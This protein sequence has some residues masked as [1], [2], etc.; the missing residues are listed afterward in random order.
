MTP[1]EPAIPDESRTDD[2]SASG[3]SRLARRVYADAGPMTRLMGAHRTRICPLEVVAASVPPGASVLDIGCGSGLML[4]ALAHAGRIDRGHGFDASEGAIKAAKG[5][6]ERMDGD[7]GRRVEFEHRRVEQG[8]P[9][10]ARD[11]VMMI[12][13]M[14]HVAAGARRGLIAEA[15]SRVRP[16]GRFIYKDMCDRPRWRATMN[17]LHDLV[18]ARQLIRYCPVEDVDR[19]AREEGLTLIESR[20]D[21]RLW[22]GHELRVFERTGGGGA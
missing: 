9:E 14:H 5:A 8:L 4:L 12:D 19:W 16:G 7:A 3:I 21:T 22:Y 11:V 15:A 18:M 17:Q 10:G 20:D 2:L 13:V 1:G 6:V